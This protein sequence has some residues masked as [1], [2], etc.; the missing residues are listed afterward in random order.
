MAFRWAHAHE[1]RL[2]AA[3]LPGLEQPFPTSP[4]QRRVG[5]APAVVY[6]HVHWAITLRAQA[7]HAP[8]PQNRGLAETRLSEEH[9]EEPALHATWELRHLIFTGKEI[10]TRLLGEGLKPAVRRVI[11]RRA[12]ALLIAGTSL[13]AG[14]AF[15]AA[16]QTILLL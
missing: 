10:T 3:Y 5:R 8:G 4:S 14:G 11:R 9:G 16:A 7:R 13:A 1:P 2:R 12:A 15:L 6:A